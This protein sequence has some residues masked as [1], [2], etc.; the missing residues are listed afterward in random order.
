MADDARTKIRERMANVE[1]RALVW[2]CDKRPDLKDKPLTEVIAVL[3]RERRPARAPVH[4]LRD[5]QL[6]NAITVLKDLQASVDSTQF[7]EPR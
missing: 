5:N 4:D 2:V 3:R 7:P 6:D 1:K